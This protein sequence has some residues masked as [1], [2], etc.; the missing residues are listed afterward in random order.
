ME[1]LGHRLYSICK[2]Q[3]CFKRGCGQLAKVT[4]S[5]IRDSPSKVLKHLF[6]DSGICPIR[7]ELHNQCFD[8]IIRQVT[9]DCPERG[10]LLMRV[11]DELKM[12]ISDYET[13]YESSVTFGMRKQL[14]S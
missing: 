9:I 2:L 5:E 8:E 12:T 10:L 1:F 14:Q 4:R 7:E 13:L 3:Q 11:R 6:R